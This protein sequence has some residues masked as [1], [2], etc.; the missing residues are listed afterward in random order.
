MAYQATEVERMCDE[1]RALRERRADA[2]SVVSDTRAAVARARALGMSVTEIA[3]R[4][5]LD[6]SSLYRTYINDEAA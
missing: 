6:R 4:L 5:G 1:L 2:A 3:T